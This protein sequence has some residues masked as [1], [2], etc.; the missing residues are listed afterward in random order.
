MICVERMFFFNV[1]VNFIGSASAL[2]FV[3]VIIQ[4]LML[5]TFIFKLDD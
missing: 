2:C 4:H 3:A 5:V 1:N